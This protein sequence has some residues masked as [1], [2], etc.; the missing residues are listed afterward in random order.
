M[1]EATTGEGLAAQVR[2][3]VS[4]VLGRSDFPGRDQLVQQLPGVEVVGGPITM[5]DLQ[6]AGGAPA[7]AVA[8][9]PIPV[10]VEVCDQSGATVGE[11]LIWVNGGYLSALEFAWWTDDP[12]RQLPGP[13]EL[14]V[15]RK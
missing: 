2:S 5:L 4:H 7:A 6:V 14:K 3:L 10:S 1:S 9:G 13:A 11:L 8:E 15:A 12:P